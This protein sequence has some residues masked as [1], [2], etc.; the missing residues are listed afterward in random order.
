M[1][2]VALAGWSLVR[3]FKAEENPLLL[4]DFPRV[5]VEEF[6][7]SVV[8]L[9]NVFMASHEPDYLEELNQAAKRYGVKMIG[10]AV[11]GTGDLSQVDE[12]AR[13]QAV[14]N[15]KAYFPIAKALGLGFFRVNTGG[16]ANGPE[17]MVQACINSYREL[18]EEGAKTGIRITIENHGGLSTDPDVVVR[19]MEEVGTPWIGTLPDF[20]NYPDEIRYE[21]IAKMAPY[22]AACHAKFREFDEN[23]EDPRID[24]KRLLGI[25]RDT[26]FDGYVCIEIPDVLKAKALL[27]KYI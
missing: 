5:A 13:K 11:D 27:E 2:E 26:G 6:G 1:M 4:L 21:G 3:R 19:I 14:A 16:Q 9:N 15:A 22:A 23:G 10:M 24:A 8:E 20:G 12:S 18:A 7:I 17:E 25:M